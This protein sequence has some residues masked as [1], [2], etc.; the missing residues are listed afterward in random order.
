MTEKRPIRYCGDC[1][2]CCRLLPLTSIGKGIGERCRHQKFGVGCTIFGQWSRPPSCSIW[3]CSW[4]R[5]PALELSR[6]D[7]VHYF[8]DP[9]PDFVVL[10]GQLFEGRRIFA[11]QV[12]VDPAHPHAHRDPALRAWLEKITQTREMVAV[13]RIGPE[14]VLA[15]IPPRLSESGTWTEIDGRGMPPVSVGELRKAIVEERM[16][17]GAGGELSESGALGPQPEEEGA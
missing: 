11:V 5:D 2:L 17:S 12:W 10:G 3:S 4:I 15:L 16:K 6:P 7:R 9:T 13:A 1:Q 14:M 8:V